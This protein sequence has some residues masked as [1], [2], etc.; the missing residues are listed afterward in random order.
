MLM[1]N[2]KTGQMTILNT[3]TGGIA[4]CKG[5]KKTIDRLFPGIDVPIGVPYWKPAHI[6]F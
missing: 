6:F 1:M 4:T 5:K 3:Q 2:N